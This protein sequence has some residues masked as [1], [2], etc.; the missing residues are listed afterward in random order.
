[1]KRCS[2]AAIAQSGRDGD[3]DGGAKDLPVFK[4]NNHI[5]ELLC[6]IE[7]DGVA[8]ARAASDPGNND[9]DEEVFAVDVGE[10]GGPRWKLDQGGGFGGDTMLRR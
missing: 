10:A 8:E 9:E 4:A 7:G 1:M 6:S 5:S 2:C 3:G